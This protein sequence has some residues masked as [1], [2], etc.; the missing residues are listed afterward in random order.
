MRVD[1]D[2]EEHAQIH[3]V[4]IRT[5]GKDASRCAVSCVFMRLT[6]DLDPYREYRLRAEIDD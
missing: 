5:Q 3:A 1:D 2:V 6:F 4:T